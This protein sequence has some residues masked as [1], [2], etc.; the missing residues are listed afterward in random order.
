MNLFGT[1]MF[2]PVVFGNVIFPTL[3]RSYANATHH[4][5]LIAQ[6]SFDLMFLFSVPVGL[7]I[8]VI[9]KPLIALLY[10][11]EFAPSAGVLSMLGVVVIFT[12]LNTI[13][14]QLLIATERTGPWNM[15]MI[16]AIITTIPLDLVLV[17][18]THTVYGNGG[19]G[20]ALSF[21][22]T[23][24]GMVICAILLL[25]KKTLQWS[26][27]RTASLSLL[28]GL[29]MMA[30]CWWLRDRNLVLAILA[31]AVVYPTGMMLLR[32]VP[33]ED[34]LLV[35]DGVMGIA[36]RLRRSK[37]APASTGN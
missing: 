24:G 4:V 9:A 23:E 37:S 15:V 34:L 28:C 14:G 2:I 27:V 32:V 11:A 20:G 30:V 21:M 17:P 1:L 13:L 29:L 16:A 6:R 36:K 19:L 3:S 22:V 26:N 7:G 31:G 35:G 8:V 5:N 10:G 12:Y 18:W 25:P 33:R